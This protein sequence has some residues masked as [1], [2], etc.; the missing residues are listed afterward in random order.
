MYC[1]FL[2]IDANFRL[3][4]KA[5]SSDAADPSLNDGASFFVNDTKYKGFIKEFGS[6]VNQDVRTYIISFSNKV[7]L[8][9]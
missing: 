8:L 6:K 5:V 1:L 7:S 4:R 9:A 3:K 2:A